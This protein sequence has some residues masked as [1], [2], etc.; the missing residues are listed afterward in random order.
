MKARQSLPRLRL[1]C[2]PYAGAGVAIYRSWSNHLPQDIEVCPV[3]LPGR[4]ARIKEPAFTHLSSLVRVLAHVLRPYMDVPFAFF[5]YSMGALISF[6]FARYLRQAQM[7]EPVHLL[8]SAHRA[9]QLP[10]TRAHI[11]SLSDAELIDKL[12]Q[13]GGTPNEILQQTELMKMML[14]TLRADFTLCETYSYVAQ[15]P[16]AYPITAFGGEQDKMVSEQELQGWYEQTQDDFMLHM[17]S[18][19]HFFLRD[20]TRELMQLIG[21]ALVRPLL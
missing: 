7:L 5:G 13:L 21:D 6:E 3:H 14:P 4:E 16:F 9:P 11:H 18:G 15:A 19:D 20:H 10:D 12:S 1:F 2:F 17:F 8:V